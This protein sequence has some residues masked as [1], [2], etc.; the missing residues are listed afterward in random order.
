MRS[1]LNTCAISFSSQHHHPQYILSIMAGNRSGTEALFHLD[2]FHW[3]F[4]SLLSWRSSED[5]FLQ[6]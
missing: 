6:Q 2:D 4:R 3:N 5:G 1:T